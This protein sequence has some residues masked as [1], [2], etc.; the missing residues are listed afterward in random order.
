MN[1]KFILFDFDGVIV[2]SF[3]AAM[4]I[5]SLIY[6]DF[7]KDDYRKKFEGS[8]NDESARWS[9]RRKS[10]LDF[11]TEYTPRLPKQKVFDGMID[12]VKSLG[13]KFNLIIISSTTSDLIKNY[14]KIHKL[15]QCFIEILGNDV[16]SNKTEKIKMVFEKYKTNAQ[17]CIFITDT[18]GDIKEAREAGAK[19]I[20]VSWGFNNRDILEKGNPLVLVDKPEEIEKEIENYFAN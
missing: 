6:S 4:E 12:V 20:A 7:T 19:S 13:E 9:D 2:D 11:F 15:E 10:D 5:N 16:H 1:K 17:N 14:L 8:V 3:Q 18:L